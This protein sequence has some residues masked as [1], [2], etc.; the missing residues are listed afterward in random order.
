MYST[1]YCHV[2]T[3]VLRCTT[4]QSTIRVCYPSPLSES[5]VRVRCPSSLS[6]STIRVC[7]PSP[8]SESAVRV[9]CPS[10]LSESADHFCCPNQRRPG[11]CPF[12]SMDTLMCPSLWCHK[13]DTSLSGKKKSASPKLNHRKILFVAN[14]CVVGAQRSSTRCY[15][16]KRHQNYKQSCQSHHFSLPK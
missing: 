8:L 16:Q 9:C 7:Y 6:E 5:A 11:M 12:T 3:D 15:Q 2:S 4:I 10:Q 14:P 13:F 1:M